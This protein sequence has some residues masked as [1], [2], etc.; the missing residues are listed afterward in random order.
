MNQKYKFFIK[1]Y[2]VTFRKSGFSEEDA[3]SPTVSVYSQEELVEAVQ[4]LKQPSIEGDRFYEVAADLH[5]KKTL[6]SEL[7][8]IVAGGGLVFD[9][10]GRALMIHRRGS[11]DLPKGKVELGESLEETAIREVEEECG[12]SDLKI[13]SEPFD[14]YHVYSE[15]GTPTIKRSVWYRMECGSE[16]EPKPQL[17]EDITEAKWVSESDVSIL[18]ANSFGSIR[19]VLHHFL[20]LSFSKTMGG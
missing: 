4:I 7:P 6:F 16:Q 3:A 10:L 17:E 20:G 14:T 15:K 5:L 2:S 12:I 11:W 1:D 13:V 9:P 8:V 18:G 19:D